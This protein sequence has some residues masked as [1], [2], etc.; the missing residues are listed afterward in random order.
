MVQQKILCICRA[1][2]NRS[3]TLSEMLNKMGFNADFS[4][5][6]NAVEKLADAHIVIFMEMDHLNYANAFYSDSI[7]DK[8]VYCLRV[9]D[10]YDYNEPKLKTLLMR[11]MKETDILITKI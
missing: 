5:L 2:A 9:P 11:R 10:N 6:S 3:R 8:N 7:K 1:G 4:G